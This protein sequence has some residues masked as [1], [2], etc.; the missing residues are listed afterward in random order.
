MDLC[1]IC[2]D[3]D[4]HMRFISPTRLKKAAASSYRGDAG[5]EWTIAQEGWNFLAP[6][7]Q[8]KRAGVRVTIP[9]VSQTE[10]KYIRILII[11]IVRHL[12]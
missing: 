12:D 11:Y 5:L 6:D 7:P 9:S 2:R 4:P 3:L 1:V 8:V 10:C